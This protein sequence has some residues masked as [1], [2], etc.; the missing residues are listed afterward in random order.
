MINRTRE[1]VPDGPVGP[2]LG[3]VGPDLGPAKPDLGPAVPL[4]AADGAASVGD[5]AISVGD[6]ADDVVPGQPQGRGFLLV[7]WLGWFGG[8]FASGSIAG[9]A[10]PKLFAFIDD[11]SKEYNLSITSVVSGIIAMIITPLFG[12]LS[13]RT[14]S[15]WG[16][17]R[18]WLFAGLAVA[19]V[20][21]ALLS[22]A[23]SLPGVL[24]GLGMG[25][26][27]FGAINM[28]LHALI[29]DQVPKRTRA[30]TAGVLGVGGSIAVLLGVQVIAFLPN[31]QRWSWFIVP[32]VIGCAMVL[33]LA[34][35]LKDIVR[36][37]PAE[38]MNWKMILSTYWLNPVKYRNFF[39]AWWCRLL[40]TMSIVS[41]TTYLLYY[42]IDVL[43]YPKETASG[44]FAQA[45][46]VFSIGNVV[47]TILFGWLSDKIGRRKPIVLISC[48]FSAVGLGMLVFSH[49]TVTFFV[50]LAVVGAAQGAFISVDIALMTEVLPSINDAGKDLG[51]VAL[52]YQLSGLLVPVVA[53][54]LLSLGG[55][56][57]YQ[58]LYVA[59]L[60]C[61]VLGGLCVIPIRGVR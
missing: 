4:P 40:V 27:G 54:P 10:V 52:S 41:V 58:A 48:L 55:G 53:I 18:P 5:G 17:R 39:W 11:A 20:G 24:L 31:D 32:G 13:D 49:D 36:T 51:V 25:Q 28:V 9:A 45:V 7:F 16:I 2:D 26:L 56:G 8:S 19:L 14:M 6:L 23:D 57:N 35:R 43:G 33:L 22:V 50:A 46:V 37:A 38:P 12:R 59:S 15:R 1:Q 30:R 34:F 42:I 21:A 3:P 47:M 61:G 44:L 29:A 60:V